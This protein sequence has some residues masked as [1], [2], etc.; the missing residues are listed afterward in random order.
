[1]VKLVI[2]FILINVIFVIIVFWL[3]GKFICK[4]FCNG[5]NFINWLVCINLK[6][7]FF[8]VVLKIR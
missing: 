7:C 3:S 5:D 1:M 2:V 6:D 4:K 8:K